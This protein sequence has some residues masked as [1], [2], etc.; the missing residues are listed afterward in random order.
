MYEVKSMH[1]FLKKKW[2][3]LQVNFTNWQIFNFFI[4]LQGGPTSTEEID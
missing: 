3:K 1:D 2:K 4:A